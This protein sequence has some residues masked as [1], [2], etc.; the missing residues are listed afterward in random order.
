MK[1]INKFISALLIISILTALV[2]GV[3][4]AATNEKPTLIYL[5]QNFEEQTVGEAP[6]EFYQT[7]DKSL[8]DFVIAELPKGDNENNKAILL[9]NAGTE[10]RSLRH[11]TAYNPIRHKFVFGFDFYLTNPAIKNTITLFL[12]EYRGANLHLEKSK[13]LKFIGLGNNLEVGSGAIKGVKL[14]ANKWYSLMLEI[15]VSEGKA[16]VYMKLPI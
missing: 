5:D 12:N 2:P 3:S 16:N 11:F 13:E 1:H 15:D 6:W 7:E 8:G 4:M 14:E 10:G 9:K